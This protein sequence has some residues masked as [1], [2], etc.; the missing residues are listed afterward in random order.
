[1]SSAP[2][3]SFLKWL[4]KHKY[5]NISLLYLGTCLVVIHFS[6]AVIHGLH[7]PAIT[8]T[9]IVVLALAGLP[10]VLLISWA[11]ERS[12]TP[13]TATPKTIKRSKRSKWLKISVA[14]LAS[15]GIFII[16]L[17]LYSRI[18]NKPARADESNVIAVLP[19]TD[20][21]QEKNQEYFGDGLAEEIINSLTRIKNFRVIGRTSSFQFKNEKADLAD[22]GEKLNASIILE[23][24]V[25]KYGSRVKITA[26]LVKAK[27]NTHIWSETY[28]RELT[29]IFQIQN[30]IA[31]QIVEKLKLTLSGT[32]KQ[33][34]SSHKTDTSVYNLYL[35][36][37]HEY[38]QQRFEES[39]VHNLEA[40]K[41]D[42]E[43]APSYAYLALSKTWMINRSFD[44]ENSAL[45]AEA[46]NYAESAIRLDPELAEGYS[47]I[48]LLAWTIER[49]FPKARNYFEKSIEL[50]PGA[51]LIKNRYCYFLNWMG[52]FKKAISL[53]LDAM[54]SDP[55]DANSYINLANSYLF[56]GNHTEADRYIKR[57]SSLFPENKH[58]QRLDIANEFYKKN[59]T[60]LIDRIKISGLADTS[61]ASDLAYY[62][63]AQLQS[64]NKREFEKM[65]VLLR[66]GIPKRSHEGN[67][68]LAQMFAVA[69]MTDSSYSRLEKSINNHE[70]EMKLFKIDPIFHPLKDQE[71]YKRI[72][73]LY[74]F[75]RY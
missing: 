66:N 7:M 27:E 45:L 13:V 8:F 6:E 29:D 55:S 23:G 56:S 74:G 68:Q 22:I 67:Y 40:I 42:P 28:D 46:K 38:R 15:I 31:E 19:F 75:D 33:R 53:A 48:A 43:Y 50:N 16:S 9:L 25:R 12:K 34:M 10:I 63:I 62:G 36:A 26:Q 1:M 64:G 52:D 49:D 57:G 72:Y 44:L 24:S 60:G 5:L 39:M 2:E 32:E 11:M 18:Y 4:R 65:L 73:K 69:G 47:A 58:L 41:R 59:Y 54:A 3:S 14:A 35:K 70:N 30:D 21:S 17:L 71:G 61:N 20:M 51:S 37:L